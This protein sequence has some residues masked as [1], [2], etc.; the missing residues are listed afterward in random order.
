MSRHRRQNPI[1]HLPMP[2]D[3]ASRVF[4]LRRRAGFD[5]TNPCAQ[6]ICNRLD[7][8]GA[9]GACGSVRG[10]AHPHAG[11]CGCHLR[12]PTRLAACKLLKAVIAMRIIRD[13]GNAST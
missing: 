3:A 9:L 1:L 2:C 6:K 7:R 12:A 11:G 10:R 4:A 13:N 8:H 5:H